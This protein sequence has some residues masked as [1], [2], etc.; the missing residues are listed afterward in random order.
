MIHQYSGPDYEIEIKSLHYTDPDG[1][2]VIKRCKELFIKYV[3]D[4]NLEKILLIYK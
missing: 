3:R 1:D 4:Y 2:Q